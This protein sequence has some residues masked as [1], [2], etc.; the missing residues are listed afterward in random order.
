MP[1]I[2]ESIESYSGKIKGKIIKPEDPL[3]NE[4]RKIWNGMIDKK[5][6]II[7]QCVDTDDVVNAIGLAREKDLEISVKGAGHNIGGN[8]ICDNGLMIDFTKMKKVEVDKD[9]KIVYVEPG[10]TL[11]DVDEV[12]QQ[13]GLAVPI[14]INSTTGISGLTLGGGIGWLTRK[15]GL[16]IDNLIFAEVVT[17]DG[18][19]VKASETENPDLYWAIR[20]GGGNFGIITEFLFKLQNV[21]P[22]VLAGLIVQPFTNAK[23]ILKQYQEIV[24]SAPKELAVWVVMRK[25]PPL[26][27]LPSEVHGK[28]VIVFAFNCLE[29]NRECNKYIDKIRSLDKPFGEHFG[30]MPFKDWQKAFDPLLTPGARNYW[31]THN[32]Q[33]FSDAALDTIIKYAGKLPSPHC[34]VFLGHLEGVMNSVPAD[35]MAYVSR[36]LKF[37]MNV[38]ARWEDKADDEKC[39]SWA[40]ELFNETAK[41]ASAGAYVNFMTGDEG[42]RVAAAYGKNYKR[43]V[44]IKRKY[45]PEN[46]FHHNQ[47]IKV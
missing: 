5:P 13:F 26:P 19:I 46:I 3:Y 30:K 17:A 33:N 1:T 4:A 27:F 29:N 8:C 6:A 36:D 20:G 12:T 7:V 44:E 21:G 37:V 24:S 10:A 34:E 41:F 11:A 31:K 38:H 45:D 2:N 18:N 23:K 28:E 32:F 15:F 39:I 43:L 25:A 42:D 47:N 9:K 35:A 16:T 14:G 22:E 40:R